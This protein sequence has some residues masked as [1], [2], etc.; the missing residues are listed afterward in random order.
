MISK[1][2]LKGWRKNVWNRNFK[3]TSKQWSRHR[4]YNCA[5]RKRTGSCYTYDLSLY[6]ASDV[7]ITK[8]QVR[9]YRRQYNLK[10]TKRKHFDP[11]ACLNDMIASLTCIK[12]YKSWFFVSFLFLLMSWFVSWRLGEDR[13]SQMLLFLYFSI[14]WNR[15]LFEEPKHV[16][17]GRA[18]KN[19]RWIWS[20]AHRWVFNLQTGVIMRVRSWIAGKSGK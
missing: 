19:G 9:E 10:H 15:H 1:G 4:P 3:V 11:C 14:F 5:L 20:E 16:G 6:V 18:Y 13:R 2:F 17:A 8:Q 12:A 7:D